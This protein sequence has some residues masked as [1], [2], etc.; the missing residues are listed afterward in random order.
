MNPSVQR[1][2][3][4]SWLLGQ[5]WGSTYVKASKNHNNIVSVERLAHMRTIVVC[6]GGKL[7]Y[8]FLYAIMDLL[9]RRYDVII[10][11]LILFC[12]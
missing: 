7:N 1:W 3:Y 11:V 6:L 4:H 8:V 2:F 5:D 12:C 9:H 10:G